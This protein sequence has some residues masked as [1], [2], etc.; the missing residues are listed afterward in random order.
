MDVSDNLGGGWRQ[1]AAPHLHRCRVDRCDA[2]SAA[3]VKAL[4]KTP[5]EQ[6]VGPED[7]NVIRQVHYQ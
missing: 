5:A 1:L 3:L 7:K 4:A 2:S 6:K